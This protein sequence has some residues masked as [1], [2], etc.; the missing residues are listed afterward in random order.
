ML[1]ADATL[2]LLLCSWYHHY[3]PSLTGYNLFLTL[4]LPPGKSGIHGFGIFAKLP[5]KAGDMVICPFIFLL[6]LYDFEQLQHIPC[7]PQVGSGGGVV[8]AIFPL[9]TC[10][11]VAILV[12]SCL[13]SFV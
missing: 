4:S 2:S 13:Y 1:L 9:T 8:Y 7:Y 3:S 12:Y 5:Q 6:Q 10:V 11:Q